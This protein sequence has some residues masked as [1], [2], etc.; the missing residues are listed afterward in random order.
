V[1]ASSEAVGASR[2]AGATGPTNCNASEKIVTLTMC[3]CK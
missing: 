1:E 2:E 3:Y